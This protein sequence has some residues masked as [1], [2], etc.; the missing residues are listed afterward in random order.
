MAK[1]S[2]LNKEQLPIKLDGSTQGSKKTRAKSKK[3]SVGSSSK[4]K[5]SKKSENPRGSTQ[6]KK[7]KLDPAR[8]KLR[9]LTEQANQIYWQQ[10]AAGQLSRAALEAE[11]TLTPTHRTKYYETS[12][13]L[14]SY[15]LPT[16]R[17]INR[18]L[19]RVM[20]FLTDYN[21]VYSGVNPDEIKS[22]KGLFGAQ[23]RGGGGQGYDPTRVSKE[24]AE[25]VFD[26]YHRV[27]EQGGGWERVIGYFRLMNP[28]IIDYGSEN[29]IN[30]IYDMVQNQEYIIPSEGN[31]VTGE[32]IARSMDIIDRMK[33]T[34][35][36]LA[37]LQRSGNDYGA[38]LSESEL[39]S[40]RAYW[41]FITR[42]RR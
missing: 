7:R 29:L 33:E 6:Q 8:E 23:W 41:N 35:E 21:Q 12:G 27:I 25:M 37:E 4:G 26:I 20:T 39:E 5:S 11:R 36:R 15:N 17:E 3:S 34:Y 40:N 18:E 16:S 22:S 1:K 42:Y 13:D 38:I 9:V 31:S 30:T 14:F 19:G 24:D 32:I 2:K 28:G 10:K